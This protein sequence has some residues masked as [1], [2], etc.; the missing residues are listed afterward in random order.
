VLDTENRVTISGSFGGEWNYKCVMSLDDNDS[1]L[2]YIPNYVNETSLSCDIDLVGASAN[3]HSSTLRLAVYREED[4]QTSNAL[5]IYTTPRYALE[6]VDPS[7]LSEAQANVGCQLLAIQS[8]QEVVVSAAPYLCRFTD[9]IGITTNTSADIIAAHELKCTIPPLIG[10]SHVCLTREDGTVQ[11]NSIKLTVLSTSQLLKL[12]PS[13]GPLPGGTNVTVQ[14][15]G[16]S[17]YSD[18]N[19]FCQFGNE[20]SAAHI[21]DDEHIHCKTPS[22]RDDNNVTFTLVQ[23]TQFRNMPISN[24][25]LS[26]QYYSSPKL[27]TITPDNGPASGGHMINL[28]IE[29]LSRSSFTLSFTSVVD[30][31]HVTY[32]KDVKFLNRTTLQVMTPPSPSGSGGG[33]VVIRISGNGQDYSTDGVYYNYTESAILHSFYPSEVVEGSCFNLTMQVGRLYTSPSHCTIGGG[34]NYPA[35]GEVAGIVT[36]NDVCLDAHEGLYQVGLM[37]D[38]DVFLPASKDIQVRRQI[39]AEEMTPFMGPIDGGTRVI[40]RGEFQDWSSQLYCFFGEHS[41]L[42]TLINDTAVQCITPSISIEE[43]LL[44]EVEDNLVGVKVYVAPS[45]HQSTTRDGSNSMVFSHYEKEVIDS[46]T[47]R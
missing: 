45:Y 37:L 21:M 20:I 46:I 41:T 44:E 35:N 3:H 38:N 27:I 22:S 40:V 2:E 26:F 15:I 43:D 39:N 12:I 29:G 25:D 36:C 5:S 14:G 10:D 18:V 13:S 4:N 34:S 24:T 19:I 23:A 30:Q 47:P 8:S 33:M 11:S 17:A 16:F 42:A 32:T 6:S 1:K 9:S 7:V 31:S 28:H